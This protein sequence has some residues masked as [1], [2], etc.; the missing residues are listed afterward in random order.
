MAP[1]LTREATEL[2]AFLAGGG[3]AL[4][5]RAAAERALTQS[6]RRDLSVMSPWNKTVSLAP[7]IVMP[8]E[9]L[10]SMFRTSWRYTSSV[11]SRKPPTGVIARTRP[12]DRNFTLTFLDFSEASASASPSVADTFCCL[13]F[14]SLPPERKPVTILPRPFFF[15]TKIAPSYK[16]W[17]VRAFLI[18]RF[19]SFTQGQ[20]NDTNFLTVNCVSKA[21]W[22]SSQVRW[23]LL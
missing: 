15:R 19:S 23:R 8:R 3:L 4:A 21:S 20:S 14:F 22:H 12:S 9:P 17:A 13:A 18:S 7:R 6:S 16:S 10:G 5:S 1:N 2:E 11:S